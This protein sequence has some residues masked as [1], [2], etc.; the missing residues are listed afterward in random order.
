M[1]ARSMVKATARVSQ[2]MLDETRPARMLGIDAGREH[3]PFI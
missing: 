1:I 2:V 3:D